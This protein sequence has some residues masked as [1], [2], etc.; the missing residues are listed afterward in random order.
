ML[1]INRPWNGSV[2]VIECSPNSFIFQTL[3]GHLEAGQ[4]TF[5]YSS[6][7]KDDYTLTVESLARCRDPLSKIQL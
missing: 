6:L 4:I 2:R 5:S 7:G 1:R 3:E